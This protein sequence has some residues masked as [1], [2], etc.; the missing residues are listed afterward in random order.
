MSLAMMD[1]LSKDN[2]HTAIDDASNS[3]SMVST[4]VVQPVNYIKLD[5]YMLSNRSNINFMLLVESLISYAHSARGKFIL[6]GAET[7]DNLD[8][9]RQLKVD[10]VQGFYY[11]KLFK[12]VS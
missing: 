7:M 4:A 11:R 8:F 5:K 10:Y 3:Q 2:I 1:N 9:A 6:E 12:N